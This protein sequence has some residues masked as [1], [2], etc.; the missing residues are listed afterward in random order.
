MGNPIQKT[1]TIPVGAGLPAMAVDQPTNMLTV[2]LQSLASQLP[3][4][5]FLAYRMLE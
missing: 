3:Q 5:L 4:V 2:R 1:T